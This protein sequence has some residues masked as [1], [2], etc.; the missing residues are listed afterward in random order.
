MV[1]KGAVPVELRE[2]GIL[3]YTPFPSRG[4]FL[5][6]ATFH[7]GAACQLAVRTWAGINPS[8]S[9]PESSS[10]PAFLVFMQLARL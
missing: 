4:I 2:E 7:P 3:S 1:R 6:P 9:I 8:T 5:C 10:L